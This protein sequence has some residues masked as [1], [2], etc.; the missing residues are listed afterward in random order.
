MRYFTREWWESGSPDA[1]SVF[2][3]YAEHMSRIRAALPQKL[4]EL[5]EQHT[6]H[7]AE[8]KH[9][10]CDFNTRTVRMSLHGW[11]QDLNSKVQYHLQFAE[12][13]HF[14]QK[15]PPQEYVEEE[16][17]DLGYWECDLVPSGVQI[18]MLFVS[19]AEFEIVFKVFNYQAL[20][21]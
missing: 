11:D 17:G 15:L 4:I 12:V 8:V 9:I 18:N 10:V 3:R 14:E 2:A 20:A 19:G 6:L 5:D 21:Q 1:E 7:D 16:L 13:Q